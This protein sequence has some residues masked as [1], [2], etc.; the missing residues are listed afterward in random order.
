[1]VDEIPFEQ[2]MN[3][4]VEAVKL[5]GY[6]PTFETPKPPVPKV[7]DPTTNTLM[8]NVKVPSKYIFTI[9]HPEWRAVLAKIVAAGISLTEPRYC[10]STFCEDGISEFEIRPYILEGIELRNGEIYII[11]N[12]RMWGHDY[13]W[14]YSLFEAA[15]DL[16][17]SEEAA[18]AANPNPPK[19]VNWRVGYW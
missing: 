18:K 12:D 1:M 11:Y 9:L 16:Y 5:K 7:I 4:I 8:P 3:G 15:Q 10:A 2:R 17:E 6:I 19:P 13:H 14:T